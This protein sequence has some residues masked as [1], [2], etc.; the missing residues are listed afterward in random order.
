VYP[1]EIDETEMIETWRCRFLRRDESIKLE[2][3]AMYR[4]HSCLSEQFQWSN[5]QKLQLFDGEPSYTKVAGEA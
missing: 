1:G 2:D 4:L 5:I 3:D